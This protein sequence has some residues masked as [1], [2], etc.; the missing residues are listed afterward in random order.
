METFR[1][2]KRVITDIRH[3][4]EEEDDEED[5]EEDEE[6][7]KKKKKEGLIETVLN[8]SVSL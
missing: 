5:E 8:R 1:T 3:E 7:K 4:E 2:A 6:K